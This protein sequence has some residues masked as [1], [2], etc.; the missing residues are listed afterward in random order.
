MDKLERLLKDRLYKLMENKNQEAVDIIQ[1]VFLGGG[2][3]IIG[4]NNYGDVIK[5]FFERESVRKIHGNV[6]NA[7]RDMNEI[8]F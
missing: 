5:R 6:M 7:W 8:V 2:E 3:Q 4:L 1:L